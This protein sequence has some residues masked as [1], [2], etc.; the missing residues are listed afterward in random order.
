[1]QTIFML[2]NKMMVVLIIDGIEIKMGMF[3]IV[4]YDFATTSKKIFWP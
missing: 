3:V 4:P 2:Y 1:M